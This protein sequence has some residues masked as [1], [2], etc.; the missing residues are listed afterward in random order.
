MKKLFLLFGFLF[1]VS[2]SAQVIIENG[3]VTACSGTFYDSG[4]DLNSYLGNENYIFTICP[5]FP[6]QFIELDFTSFVTQGGEDLMTIYNSD[7][8]DAT[9][10]FGIFSG[11]TSPGLVSAT[12]TNVSGCI[13]I[14]F[15][16]SPGANF[17]G[18]SADISCKEPCQTINSQVD[19]AFP[20]PNANG[21]IKVCPDEE[22]TLTGSGLFSSNGAGA[23]Y[24]WDLGD[25]STQ[26]GQTATFSYSTPGVYIVNLNIRDT[27]TSND[28]EGCANTN[29]INQVIQVGTVPD[30]VGTAALQDAICFGDSTTIEGVVTPTPFINDCTPPV[31]E[32]TPLP[33]GNG[34]DYRTCITV[35]CYE[36]DLTLDTIDQLIDICLNIEHSYLGDLEITI[37]SPNGLEAT[38]K[39]YPF[40]FG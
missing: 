30:F 3:T 10:S 40:F 22:I 2:L 31:S 11:T 9:L 12:T 1:S 28:P 35:D 16:S 27:N 21:F 6:G 19:T 17:Q 5:E 38:L 25:G 24:E 29:L 39:N 15:T 32:L 7:T 18:W 26:L 20:A 36:S 37:I 4:G 14:E 33:D 8:N 34:A 23:A 13:T